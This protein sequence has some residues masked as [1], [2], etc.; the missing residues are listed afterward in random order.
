MD[1]RVTAEEEALVFRLPELL[2]AGTQPQET[3]GG[4]PWNA[5]GP[6]QIGRR[7]ALSS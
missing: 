1:F 2:E 7:I 4:T 5:T 3:H 6:V